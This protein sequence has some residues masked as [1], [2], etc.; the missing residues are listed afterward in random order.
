M[1]YDITVVTGDVQYAGTDT[2]IF[3]TVFGA[4]GSAE[5]ILLP[6]NGDR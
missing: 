3:L 1:V 2:N 4:N 6:K 5:E